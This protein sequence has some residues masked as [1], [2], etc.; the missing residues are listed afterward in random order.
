MK[1]KDDI[2]KISKQHNTQ[3][4]TCKSTK[5]KEIN[6]SKNSYSFDN[7]NCFSV[8]ADQI[9][10]ACLKCKNQGK[11]VDYVFYCPD[12]DE[13]WIVMV[14]DTKKKKEAAKTTPDQKEHED[15]IPNDETLL[16]R[17]RGSYDVIDSSVRKSTIHEES[18][19]ANVGE[20]YQDKYSLETGSSIS[21]TISWISDSDTESQTTFTSSLNTDTFETLYSTEVETDSIDH[22]IDATNIT[23]TSSTF[24]SKVDTVMDSQEY[25]HPQKTI[26]ETEKDRPDHKSL[27]TSSYSTGSGSKIKSSYMS[28]SSSETFEISYNTEIET[29]AR[30]QS[31]EATD[32][33]S[34][35][36]RLDSRESS[37]N[38][39]GSSLTL[40]V[41]D[42]K[43][44]TETNRRDSSQ[45]RPIGSLKDYTGFMIMEKP[46]SERSSAQNKNGSCTEDQT[47][48]FK[49]TKSEVKI[50][51]EKGT[52][53]NNIIIPDSITAGKSFSR[54]NRTVITGDDKS[55]IESSQPSVINNIIPKDDETRPQGTSLQEPSDTS[56]TS[57]QA[58]GSKK[59]TKTVTFDES[60]TIT[61]LTTREG[62]IGSIT[63][64]LGEKEFQKKKPAIVENIIKA[65]EKEDSI[66]PVPLASNE[67]HIDTGSDNKKLN[68]HK[69]S[70]IEGTD[71]HS[72]HAIKFDDKTAIEL[73]TKNET[74]QT[75]M[76][77]KNL[78]INSK[79]IDSEHNNEI[80][81]NIFEKETV[82]TLKMSD[83]SSHKSK[84]EL[85]LES[86]EDIGIKKKGTQTRSI[87]ESH[88]EHMTHEN[89]ID[90]KTQNKMQ[91]A[92]KENS[93]VEG[94]S[95]F[96]GENASDSQDKSKSV[97]HKKYVG[98][99]KND[100]KDKKTPE[101]SPGSIYGIIIDIESQ[102]ING[103][104]DE[105]QHLEENMPI[106]PML[107][108]TQKDV[109]E[110]MRPQAEVKTKIEYFNDERLFENEE[111][112]SDIPSEHA[113]YIQVLQSQ[114]DSNR[115]IEETSEI[116]TEPTDI[117][118][119]NEK[120][121]S[122]SVETLS[123]N[124]DGQIFKSRE[125]TES[126]SSLEI[127]LK[128][129][130]SRSHISESTEKS[131]QQATS[132]SLEGSD[133]VKEP[134]RTAVPESIS[135]SQPF[136]K[137]QDNT[138]SDDVNQGTPSE[139][140]MKTPDIHE[141]KSKTK[142]ERGSKSTSNIGKSLTS[143]VS[144]N[145]NVSDGVKE[146][147]SS[148][149]EGRE[150]THE[151][152]LSSQTDHIHD[153][154]H[155]SQRGSKINAQDLSS[156]LSE[157][158][159]LQMS[160]KD[161]SMPE[162]ILASVS[163]KSDTNRSKLE[164][165]ALKQSSLK[166]KE[167]S[168]RTVLSKSSEERSYIVSTD[169]S[170][171]GRQPDITTASKLRKERS[172]ISIENK[173]E[174]PNQHNIASTSLLD[175]NTTIS[176]SSMKTEKDKQ[177]KVSS[178]SKMSENPSLVTATKES[179]EVLSIKPG[180]D[181]P[182]KGDR[183]ESVD[184]KIT[185]KHSVSADNTS[186]KKFPLSSKSNLL[187]GSRLTEED[188]SEIGMK[189]SHY[190]SQPP[191]DID[192]SSLKSSSQ[193]TLT[194][195][196]LI[197]ID[198]TIAVNEKL[199]KDNKILTSSSIDYK[200]ESTDSKAQAE[201]NTSGS[202]SLE[203]MLSSSV[204]ET[205]KFETPI[206]P[207]DRE[208]V[209]SAVMN[210]IAELKES[211]SKI[212]DSLHEN[213][214]LLRETHSKITDESLSKDITE[215]PTN[216]VTSS[217]QVA[218]KEF[219]S[220][221][222]DEMESK[223]S[224]AN[225]SRTILENKPRVI[226]QPHP[227]KTTPDKSIKKKPSQFA[228]KNELVEKTHKMHE[229]S[230]DKVQKKDKNAIED[231]TRESFA[232]TS[233]N[234]VED[235]ISETETSKKV[236]TQEPTAEFR[237]NSTNEEETL[238]KSLKGDGDKEPLAESIKNGIEKEKILS[239]TGDGDE[240]KEPTEESSKK[241]IEE[242]RERSQPDEGSKV[243]TPSS[244]ISEEKT[245]T[246][247]G[248]FQKMDKDEVKARPS[249]SINEH[250]QEETE[251]YK[252]QKAKPTKEGLAKIT[253]KIAK[254]EKDEK[255]P[256]I[257]A[258]EVEMDKSPRATKGDK[259][260]EIPK[261]IPEKNDTKENTDTDSKSSQKHETDESA[262][263]TSP[264]SEL[265]ITITSEDKSSKHPKEV[266]I[267]PPRRSKD[268][269]SSDKEENNNIQGVK[270]TKSGIVQ[271]DDHLS[272]KTKRVT[273]KPIKTKINET[274]Q[275]EKSLSIISEYEQKLPKKSKVDDFGKKPTDTFEEQDSILRE[276]L[277]SPAFGTDMEYSSITQP[278]LEEYSKSQVT[279]ADS[280]RGYSKTPLKNESIV[281]VKDKKVSTK[282]SS[283]S[284][285]KKSDIVSS[286]V[287]TKTVGVLEPPNEST[288]PPDFHEDSISFDSSS[289][290]FP[291]SS[292][293]ADDEV[294][295]KFHLKRAKRR[296]STKRQRRREM[297]RLF[298]RMTS[299]T[300]LNEKPKRIYGKGRVH[301]LI[302][303]YEHIIQKYDKQNQ[304]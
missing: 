29:D 136:I 157:K 94:A 19:H 188:K 160:K 45:T 39:V 234:T 287:I 279:A 76:T 75:I 214:K 53:S 231:R 169:K 241:T 120:G 219:T 236:Q 126:Q 71:D 260:E 267:V 60:K 264:E 252:T 68:D 127:P 200:K 143:L 66:E 46:P 112:K 262:T 263:L 36:T 300:N 42:V 99:A 106:P 145:L 189:S 232:D 152:A 81:S 298:S 166:L 110:F 172:N 95:E 286:P 70:A 153:I 116:E 10:S 226:D 78:P 290:F 183:E 193:N 284:K 255:Q 65:L 67:T 215:P 164:H 41:G 247:K 121:M 280:E 80:E 26:E 261:N 229:E 194:S 297:V 155:V 5:C 108:F 131:E 20:P 1:E 111:F 135:I 113:S 266:E 301:Q 24:D 272:D 17:R 48:S 52:E 191:T 73:K 178:A 109:N 6:R 256:K 146:N 220:K 213:E 9:K 91:E 302:V 187:D 4:S 103:E 211:L 86:S 179:E 128:K 117:K 104:E 93:L 88:A 79:K 139:Y 259:P 208:N 270:N 90:T 44:S 55:F 167:E 119:V 114:V 132:I 97:T 271:E 293:R 273:K 223:K 154:E 239:E 258:K 206:A 74:T 8:L 16:I 72:V 27:E 34:K 54:R 50:L 56:M 102:K 33:T 237:K 304:P 274:S 124:G 35:T 61:R 158:D 118:S 134:A 62:D 38:D 224:D 282:E 130:S 150:A 12:C 123:L 182:E 51:P 201:K 198:S 196:A 181:Q 292:S 235:E 115:V 21:E 148:S 285:K 299:S 87:S 197:G 32:I 125:R 246:E 28:S 77:P 244:V 147:K 107:V 83:K 227:I 63:S 122:E 210:S 171:E 137:R 49:N 156:H 92:L 249:I 212:T 82:S 170:E 7:E 289:S 168:A 15:Q 149:T 100:F 129:K 296:N 205:G 216:I 265:D 203:Q 238:T 233:V 11:N 283:D 222:S 199:F 22:S 159:Q 217:S 221:I 140:L 64:S 144:S 180:P 251:K 165:T 3:G 43:K 257:V 204:T 218:S 269:I 190:P 133:K 207:K 253:E 186:A 142:E 228:D 291:E 243:T 161:K 57:S 138:S 245:V 275:N 176:Q 209:Q 173:S 174:E 163:S 141:E 58:S 151:T 303:Y 30:D 18:E 23:S 40:I 185:K 13:Y 202:A 59:S 242:H 89:H 96:G 47:R 281:E 175:K 14:K 31:V 268:H 254:N 85:I 69:T 250:Q 162:K 294:V 184:K 195:S 105:L 240:S 277:E 225:L 248:T 84:P 278:S 276:K 2:K 230:T 177:T 295:P 288:Q 37:I 98:R 101:S 192:Q 25:Q